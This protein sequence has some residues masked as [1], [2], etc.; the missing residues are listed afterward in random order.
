MPTYELHCSACGNRFER[1][2]TRI[3]RSE[4]KVCPSCGSHDVREGLGG[5]Y[6]PPRAAKRHEAGTCAPRGGFG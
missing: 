5:G 3:L 1:F 4:D 2:L 6:A